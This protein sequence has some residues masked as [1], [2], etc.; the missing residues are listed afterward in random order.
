MVSVILLLVVGLVCVDSAFECGLCVCNHEGG[1]I[2]AICGGVRL[3]HVPTFGSLIN[4]K[5]IVLGL[6]RNGIK[7]V[8][9]EELDRFPMLKLLDLREQE[10][11]VTL[12]GNVPQNVD[13][14]GVYLNLKLSK[15]LKFCPNVL[16]S[17]SKRPVPPLF[18]STSVKRHPPPSHPWV[19][20][21][22]MVRHHLQ[23]ALRARRR[24]SAAQRCNLSW[25]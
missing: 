4:N 8:T 21:Q 6:A 22:K 10:D 15:A 19:F 11:C 23:A 24:L 9:V 18:Q 12:A 7:S 20:S 13:I 5:V 16:L 25:R 14:Y 1:G 2:R 3:S 17:Y